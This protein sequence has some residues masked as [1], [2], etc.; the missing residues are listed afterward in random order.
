MALKKSSR[1]RSRKIHPNDAKT[2][3]LKDLPL[4][5]MASQLPQTIWVDEANLLVRGEQ[6]LATLRFFTA[7]PEGKMEACRVQTTLSH[8]KKIVDVICR[9]LDYVPDTPLSNSTS[10]SHGSKDQSPSKIG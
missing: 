4:F 7:L 5:P 9:S 2:V 3:H 6:P 1:T 10:T 8:L